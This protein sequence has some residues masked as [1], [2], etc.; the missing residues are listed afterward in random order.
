MYSD[1]SYCKMTPNGVD[2]KC[3]LI[4]LVHYPVVERRL[5]TA[6]FL[7]FVV[8]LVLNSVLISVLLM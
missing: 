4:H 6:I 3:D 1:L 5:S 2:E 7:H 8:D